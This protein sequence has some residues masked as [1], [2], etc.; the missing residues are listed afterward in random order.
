[1]RKVMYAVD[2]IVTSNYED[3][4]DKRDVKVILE[5]IDLR[6]EKEKEYIRKRAEKV[7]RI[8]KAKRG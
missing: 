6:S 4:A 3:V 1:M 8:L 2:G 5:D 7:Q